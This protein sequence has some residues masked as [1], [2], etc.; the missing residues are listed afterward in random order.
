MSVRYD[1][2]S[3]WPKVT[4]YPCF[5]ENKDSNTIE[6]TWVSCGNALIWHASKWKVHYSHQRHIL[7]IV[8]AAI[9]WTELN[10]CLTKHEH[11]LLPF[12]SRTKTLTFRRG[13]LH[14]DQ[15][16]LEVHF[17][18]LDLSL[19]APRPLGVVKVGNGIVRWQVWV[20]GVDQYTARGIRHCLQHKCLANEGHLDQGLL[21]FS[22][23]L[24][25]VLLKPETRNK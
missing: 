10:Y 2:A 23:C 12:F 14:H 24:H 4:L 25:C 8:T 1:L 7:I 13:E 16:D 5:L 22:N 11:K 19:P 3:A 20:S 17:T 18:V 9:D 21:R 6:K 15:K